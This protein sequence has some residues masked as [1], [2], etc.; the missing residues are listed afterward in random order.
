MPPLTTVRLD[1]TPH[2][3]LARCHPSLQ[4][5][6]L[7]PLTAVR[8]ASTSHCFPEES[9]LTPNF[10]M[11]SEH[12]SLVKILPKQEAVEIH[13]ALQVP[14]S[15]FF[16]EGNG[17]EYRKSFHGYPKVGQGHPLGRPKLLQ[18]LCLS[19]RVSKLIF[20]P[21]IRPVHRVSHHLPHTAHAD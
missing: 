11:L 1:A 8:L 20:H 17:G 5:G 14:T 12:C 7:Q 15:Q 2:C 9:F 13:N 21:G 6:S 16:S 3:S 18:P 10:G 4:L 19:L